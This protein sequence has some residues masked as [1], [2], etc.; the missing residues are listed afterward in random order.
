[1]P[2]RFS[3][4]QR[5][6]NVFKVPTFILVLT[7][8]LVN[9]GA[10]GLGARGSEG[11][12]APVKTVQAS[13]LRMHSAQLIGSLISNSKGVSRN[14]IIRNFFPSPLRARALGSTF[15]NPKSGAQNRWGAISTVLSAPGL[16]LDFGTYFLIDNP[17]VVASETYEGIGSKDGVLTIDLN[18]TG[19]FKVAKLY[20][21][22]GELDIK[23]K[24]VVKDSA[25]KVDGNRLK[26]PIY[27]GQ[28]FF[29]DV[30][31]PMSAPG[32]QRGSIVIQDGS[33][34]TLEL[35]G[36]IESPK[37]ELLA[38]LGSTQVTVGHH[39]SVNLA[40]F[41]CTN[42]IGNPNVSYKVLENP[43]NLAIINSMTQM[44]PV[45]T[46]KTTVTL[47]ATSESHTGTYPVVIEIS[48]FNGHA[49]ATVSTQVTVT[50]VWVQD[51]IKEK[52]F[53][54]TF[55]GN[56]DGDWCVTVTPNPS[57]IMADGAYVGVF[58]NLTFDYKGKM[59]DDYHVFGNT[60]QMTEP[61]FMIA[62]GND[63]Y[64]VEHYVDKL[65][66]K[67]FSRIRGLQSK[68][69]LDK[70]T[71]RQPTWPNGEPTSVHQLNKG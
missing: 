28:S 29:I 60:F 53:E 24:P 61:K 44:Q 70:V 13:Y 9:P 41:I 2:I 43:G 54:A 31:M 57:F 10:M 47:T 63:P 21:T 15:Q 27:E 7:G 39:E 71:N 40:L 55:L 18:M 26:V 62:A 38:A 68:A 35:K 65:T 67:T 12:A 32:I 49:K 20:T 46:Q 33:N 58:G 64:I 48:G 8:L 56:S 23:G 42:G 19:P 37:G 22:T 51:S 14:R 5:L 52:N 59:M 1:M 50:A 34:S 25:V 16:L 6:T 45:Q 30:N 69:P 4:L 3:S 36:K 17:S 11:S 66:K